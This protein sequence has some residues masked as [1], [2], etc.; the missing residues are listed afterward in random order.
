MLSQTESQDERS[1]L[2]VPQEA[3]RAPD[4]ET[5]KETVAAR[6]WEERGGELLFQRHRKMKSYGV[7]DGDNGCTII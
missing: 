5:E 4:S 1:M 7:D 6:R 2:S 3:L